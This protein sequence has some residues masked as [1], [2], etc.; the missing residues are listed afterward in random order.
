MIA[1]VTTLLEN[2]YVQGILVGGVLWATNKVAGLFGASRAGKLASTLTTAAGLMTQYAL[3]ESA[4][5]TAA[6]MVIAFKGIVAITFAKAG[7]TEKQRQT[8]QIAIDL[9]INKAVTEWV[10]LHPAPAGLTMPITEKLTEKLA[11]A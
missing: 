9:A 2:S 1:I 4:G 10:K 7:Y 11:A 5:K 3:T 8:F 6:Q